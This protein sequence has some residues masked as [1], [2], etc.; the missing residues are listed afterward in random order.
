[1][2]VERAD[3]KF[4]FCPL[5]PLFHRVRSVFENKMTDREKKISSFSGAGAI[6][7]KCNGTE[8]LVL[9][10]ALFL[11]NFPLVLQGFY[12]LL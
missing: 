2:F 11:Y 1:M 8:S 7:N 9:S 10:F 3:L 12:L 6:Q 5:F 4:A